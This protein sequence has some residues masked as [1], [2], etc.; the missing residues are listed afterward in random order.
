MSRWNPRF[1]LWCRLIGKTPRELIPEPIMTREDVKKYEGL[2]WTVT[3][4]EWIKEK[5]REWE[6][7]TSKRR[8][9]FCPPEKVETYQDSRY[10]FSANDHDGF[11][12]WLRRHVEER[13]NAKEVCDEGNP[14]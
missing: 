12:N 11:D 7:M 14:G 5:W 9:E 10:D 2:P 8:F 4:M 3:F 6:A 1:V 13:L